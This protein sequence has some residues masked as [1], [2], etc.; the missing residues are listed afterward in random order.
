MQKK[1]TQSAEII[2]A[3]PPT[4]RQKLILKFLILTGLIAM[5]IF[6]FWFTQSVKPGHLLLFIPLTFALVFKL[7]RILHEWYHYIS[8]SVPKKPEKI[9]KRW[10]VDMFTTACPGEPKDMIVRTL[11]AMVAV[12]YPHTSY[13]CD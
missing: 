1:I 8:I 10:T 12:T 2:K 11:K 3:N 6:I 13:L 7:L 9:S 5:I 4:E